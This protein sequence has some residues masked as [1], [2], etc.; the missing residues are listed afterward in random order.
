MPKYL[1]KKIHVTSKTFLY[2]AFQLFI[3]AGLSLFI[4][5]IGIYRIT[6]EISAI[7]IWPFAWGAFIILATN[8]MRPYRVWIL[9][10]NT[11][12]S[13]KWWTLFRWSQE[14]WFLSLITPMKIGHFYTAYRIEKTGCIPG[15][16][17]FAVIMERWSDIL[18]IYSFGLCAILLQVRLSEE[19]SPLPFLS[20]LLVLVITPVFIMKSPKVRLWIGRMLIRVSPQNI[21][22]RLNQVIQGLHS[23]AISTTRSTVLKF[24]AVSLII[25]FLI[26][27]GFYLIFRS[28]KV[29]LGI[30]PFITCLSLV[31]LVQSIPIT[32]FGFGTREAALIFFLNHYSIPMSVSLSL[33]FIFVV[34]L[35]LSMIISGF[36]WFLR[37][38]TSK[39][40]GSET[41]ERINA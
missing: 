5:K 25:W 2:W 3:I 40:L 17:L 27:I 4:S 31:L 11:E 33:S 15:Q 36:F 20:V 24:T 28:I 7:K 34:L 6:D 41:F 21:K 38:R 10:N 30:F 18:I 22:D 37:H 1:S 32:F 14:A 23:S 26:G 13:L 39:G 12:Y 9:L 35:L 29:N 16:G 19:L 8:L